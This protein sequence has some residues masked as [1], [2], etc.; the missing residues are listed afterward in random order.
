LRWFNWL[1]WWHAVFGGPVPPA[2]AHRRFAVAPEPRALLVHAERR[3]FAVAPE[4]RVF[5][6]LP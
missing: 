1:F 3:A 6:V 2:P 4:I 5:E